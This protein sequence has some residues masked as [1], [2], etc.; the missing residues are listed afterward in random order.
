MHKA[1]QDK[2][3]QKIDTIFKEL[4]L[5]KVRSGYYLWI[6]FIIYIYHSIH[7]AD[8]KNLATIPMTK[9][10][11]EFCKDTD[12]LYIR[13][14]RNLRTLIEDKKEEIQNYFGYH[15]KINNKTFLILMLEEI[16]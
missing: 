15:N 3:E 2:I 4:G 8:L 11:R 16:Q 13:L 14:E 7:N 1:K 12:Y 9:L 6:D 10:C 5:S